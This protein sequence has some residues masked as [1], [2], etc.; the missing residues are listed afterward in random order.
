MRPRRLRDLRRDQAGSA[1]VESAILLPALLAV[2]F[3]G[4]E[5]GRMAWT[6][7]TLTYAVQEAARFGAVRKAATPQQVRLVAAARAVGVR[8]APEDF[9]VAE[10]ACGVQ[11]T[12]QIAHGFLIY[13]LAPSFPPISARAC[14]P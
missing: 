14:R 9:Q 11:V 10:A 7:A 3:G 6:R 5:I 4:L 12:G 1:A 13:K 2:L 8:T